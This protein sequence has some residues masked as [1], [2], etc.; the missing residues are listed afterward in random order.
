MPQRL[1][2]FLPIGT[3]AVI[4][5]MS[6]S[7]IT[8]NLPHLV[9]QTTLDLYNNGSIDSDTYDHVKIQIDTASVTIA[10]SLTMLVG[11]FMVW[12]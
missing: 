8:S 6:S 2:K 10:V 4:S 3:Y 1:Y 12:L 7:V 5:L 11:L 9:E